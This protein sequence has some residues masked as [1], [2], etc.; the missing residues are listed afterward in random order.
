MSIISY[1]EYD[2][3]IFRAHAHSGYEII[4]VFEGDMTIT[5]N[6]TDIELKQGEGLFVP[7]YFIHGFNTKNSSK[8][9]IW[10]FS[11]EFI[12]DK[13]FKNVLKVNIPENVFKVIYDMTK[14]GTVLSDKAV[15]YIFAS[16]FLEKGVDIKISAANDISKKAVSYIAENFYNPITLKDVAEYCNVN[17]S[18]LSRTFFKKEGI[19]FTAFLNAIRIDHALMLLSDTNKP[20]TEIAFE[21]GFSS[22]RNFNRVFEH[23]MGTSPS[24]FRNRL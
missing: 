10:E 18:Y 21:S 23:M 16:I 1:M 6:N 12:K 14:L 7:S 5:V 11:Q 13:F 17:Y 8:C 4:S 2:N 3:L 24:A 15:I 22:I 20:I 9:G 19:P